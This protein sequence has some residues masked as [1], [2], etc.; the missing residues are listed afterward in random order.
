MTTGKRTR[1]RNF[2]C[3]G[4]DSLRGEKSEICTYSIGIG[5]VSG[6]SQPA[7]EMVVRASPARH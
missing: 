7:A 4:A 3:A 2:K 5:E 6:I 1:R